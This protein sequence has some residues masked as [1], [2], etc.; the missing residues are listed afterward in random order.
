MK[1]PKSDA[2]KERQ[3][4]FET[5]RHY[6]SCKHQVPQHLSKE[7]LMVALGILVGEKV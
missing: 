1:E 6:I 3:S 2:D 7:D 4:L 5:L